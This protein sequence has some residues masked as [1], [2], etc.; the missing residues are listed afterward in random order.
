MYKLTSFHTCV[1]YQVYEETG[2][3]IRQ[4]IKE[5]DFI[6][7]MQG[8]H[9]ARMYIIC[10]VSEDIVFEPKARKEIKVS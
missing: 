10:G 9:Q 3:D 4:L 7:C 8:D 6:E 1:Y 2:L 5:D